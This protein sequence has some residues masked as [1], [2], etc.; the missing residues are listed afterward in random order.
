MRSWPVVLITGASTGVGLALAQRLLGKPY[1]LV[2]TARATSLHRFATAGIRDNERLCVLPLDITHA[3]Q[4]N[5]ALDRIAERWNGVDMLI[6]NAGI[7]Y[8]A[9]VEHMSDAE[10]MHQLV[11]NYVGAMGLIRLVLPWMRSQ[12]AGR[13]IN[14]SSVSGMMA[15]PTMSAYSA[16]KFALEGASEALWY[17]MRPWNIHVSI[18]EPGFIHSQS[19]EHVYTAHRATHDDQPTDPYQIYYDSMTPFIARMMQRAR[20]TADDVAHTIEHT[21]ERNRPPLRIPATCDARVFFWLRRVLPRGVYH[22]I[23]FWGLPNIRRWGVD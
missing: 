16:S 10:E 17:E 9:V 19:F 18:V 13:I 11:T 14:V 22:R 23:L 12:R 21:M 7:S 4:R 1:R 20:A 5:T 8:R 2:L 6:N 15:M 3:A